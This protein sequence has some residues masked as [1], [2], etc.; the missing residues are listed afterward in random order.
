M[1]NSP[2]HRLKKIIFK[3]TQIAS[4]RVFVNTAYVPKNNTY[5]KWDFE[6]KRITAL[7]LKYLTWLKALV[8]KLGPLLYAEQF[9]PFYIHGSVN[10]SSKHDVF[11][12]WLGACLCMILFEA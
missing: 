7:K 10:A 9:K 3:N 8:E 11:L 12:Y 2:Q 4:L 5:N 1:N 6:L